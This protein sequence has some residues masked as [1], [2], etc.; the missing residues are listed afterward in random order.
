MF[1]MMRVCND[2]CDM[3]VTVQKLVFI[4]RE[5]VQKPKTFDIDSQDWLIY[6]TFSYHDNG[7]V[8]GKLERA[9]LSEQFDTRIQW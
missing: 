7:S 5:G 3:F 9:R 6:T 4:I 1:V 8:G 2:A